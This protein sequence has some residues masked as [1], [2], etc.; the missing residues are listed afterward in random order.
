MI[1][2][3]TDF[4][5][6]ERFVSQL[7]DDPC[8]CSPMLSDDEAIQNNLLRS[9]QRPDLHDTFGVYSSGILTGVF[10]FTV[11]KED[12]YLEM[13]VGLSREESAY[14]EMFCY[15]T[16]QYPGFRAD[17]VFNPRNALLTGALKARGAAFYPEQYKMVYNGMALPAAKRESDVVLYTSEYHDGYAALHDDATGRYWTAEK[18]LEAA[19]KFR[20]LLALR[21]GKVVG[22]IDV[23]HN[24]A[25]NE[26]FDLFVAPGCRGLGYGR[27]LLT[28]ALRMNEPRGMML[29]VDVDNVPA[30]QL[31]ESLGFKKKERGGSITAYLTVS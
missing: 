14:A 11:L 9:I 4:A 16:A 20:V 22:Y 8:Y 15:L 13:L 19:D 10:C 29:L 25:E 3:I 26:P 27:A 12:Q 7:Q 28:K 31:Y 5:R 21:N 17:F 2:K 24:F 6:I 1:Q 18:V 30:L 23:T